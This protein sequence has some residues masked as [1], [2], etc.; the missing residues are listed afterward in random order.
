MNVLQVSRRNVSFGT[1]SVLIQGGSYG[2][3]QGVAL[4]RNA[5]VYC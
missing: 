1:L 5:F 4:W 3:E 2:L